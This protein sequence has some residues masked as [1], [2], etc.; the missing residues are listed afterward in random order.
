MLGSAS[1]T[2][3]VEYFQL[4]SGDIFSVFVKGEKCTVYK[5]W[6]HMGTFDL[7]YPDSADGVFE[8]MQLIFNSESQ[9]LILV[10][11]ETL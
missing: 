3:F 9:E 1:S 2:V 5:D 11:K 6:A 10:V 8:P 7:S 4:R